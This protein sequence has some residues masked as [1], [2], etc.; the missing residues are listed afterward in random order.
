[1]DR[2]PFSIPTGS[3]RSPSHLPLSLLRA[4]VPARFDRDWSLPTARSSLG[5]ALRFLL[6]G[7]QAD[8][9][10]NPSRNRVLPQRSPSEARISFLLP[11]IEKCQ[12]RPFLSRP[13]AQ[14]SRAPAEC[15]GA[16]TNFT[17]LSQPM[18]M[19]P[20]TIKFNPSEEDREEVF[21]WLREFNQLMVDL[22][23]LL[24]GKLG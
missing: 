1:M 20:S 11:C 24:I 19:S 12:M 5:R 9:S 4:T 3:G 2:S 7:C 13:N 17:P 6:I 8:G 21:S 18:K 23:S 15:A 22:G 10:P 16:T 14:V